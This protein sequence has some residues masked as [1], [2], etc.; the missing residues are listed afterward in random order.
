MK[1]TRGI[2]KI[3][4][5]NA[6]YISGTRVTILKIRSTTMGGVGWERGG[7]P[8]SL[9]CQRRINRD[10]LCDESKKFV[11]GQGACPA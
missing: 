1:F 7:T 2:H 11:I 6:A 5:M 4:F 10:T 9:P 3:S 8:A